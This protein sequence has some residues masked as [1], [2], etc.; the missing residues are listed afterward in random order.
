MDDEE[1]VRKTTSRMLERS[2]YSVET[3]VAG[4]DAL[5]KYAAA[6]QRGQ[7]FDVSIMDLT[8]PGGM[9]GKEA[10]QELLAMDPTA[11]VIVS[12]G[13]SSDP[14]LADFAHYGFAGALAKPF[15]LQELKE[16]LSHAVKTQ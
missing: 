12:S 6:M 4:R 9:G 16:A 14:V 15:Q 10:I 2:G 8:I 1:V 7:R 13:Y 5:D 3:A 11:R